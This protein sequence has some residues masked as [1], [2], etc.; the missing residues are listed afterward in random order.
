M[1]KI[2]SSKY[3]LC[4]LLSSAVVN[5]VLLINMYM[6]S[7]YK[8]NHKLSWSTRAAAEAEAVASLMCSGHGR[9]YLDSLIVA[10]RPVCECNTCFQGPDCADFQSGCAADVNSGDPLFL[11]PFWKQHA[12]SSAVVVAGWHRMSYSY[13]DH[14]FISQELV[15]YIR[16]VHAIVG[17]AVT[18]K[19]FIVFGAGSTQLLNA[20]VYALSPKNASTPTRVLA[21]IP[22][23]PVYE[24]QTDFFRSIDYVFQGDTSM[25][26]N[27]S[28]TSTN[29]VEFVT[30]PNNPDG[31]LKKAVLQVPSAKQIY[32]HAYFWPHFTAI[33]APSDEDLMIF[34]ISKL[35]GHASSRFGWALIKDEAVYQTMSKY[36]GYSS[37][38]AS[39]DAQLRA[40]QLLKVV[41]GEEREIFKFTYKTMSSRWEKLSEALSAS[42]RFS[43]QN[44]PPTYCNF[45]QKVRG[46]SPAYAW[47]KC[48]REED[49]DC[50]EVLKANGIIG[51]E[52]SLFGAGS[53][54][55][56]L[57]LIKSQDYFDLLLD[58]INKLVSREDGAR[59]M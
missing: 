33:T 36:M 51:R 23:Y 25:W 21:S 28:D 45:F 24:T 15:K 19:R 8:L 13:A 52:G 55:V 3:V 9:A 42:Q 44:I 59:T 26:K 57:S 37:F 20:A 18:D 35:T 54:Y 1:G 43:L 16:R 6:G 49:D 2:H 39:R 58:R 50:F 17:N 56:R 46:P 48:E 14:T 5:L 30:S 11:E 10:G 53:R 38:G 22:Y 29:L 4:L 12:A 7:Y 41:V 40:L 47:V 31:Q 27:S 32:D 34:T